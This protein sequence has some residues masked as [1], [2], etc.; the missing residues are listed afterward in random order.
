MIDVKFVRGEIVDMDGLLI[1]EAWATADRMGHV[2][3]MLESETL[4]WEVVSSN[5]EQFR[6]EITGVLAA[7]SWQCVGIELRLCDECEFPLTEPWGLCLGDPDYWGW[8]CDLCAW[9]SRA[10][11]LTEYYDEELE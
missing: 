1:G 2:F 10:G 7:Y 9:K 5:D 3:N 11:M 8:L 6:E 4:D